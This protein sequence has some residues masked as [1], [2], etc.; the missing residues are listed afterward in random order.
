MKKLFFVSAVLVMMSISNS[1]AKAAEKY[2]LLSEEAYKV[3]SDYL[4][5][6]VSV[7]DIF[8]TYSMDA[9]EEYIE[10]YGDIDDVLPLE[11]GIE[12]PERLNSIINPYI[13]KA[14]KLAEAR[15]QKE[16]YKKR[17]DLKPLKNPA[18]LELTALDD[19]AVFGYEKIYN[20]EETIT[21]SIWD[22]KPGHIRVYH[23]CKICGNEAYEA[24]E[25][26]WCGPMCDLFWVGFCEKCGYEAH[27]HVADLPEAQNDPNFLKPH[28]YLT[29][30]VQPTCDAEGKVTTTC[31]M[32]LR[33]ETE[34]LPKLSHEYEEQVVTEPTFF[35]DGEI[36]EICK[37]CGEVNNTTVVPSKTKELISRLPF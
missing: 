9:I 29:E 19:Y 35:K 34:V 15:N 33:E 22:E 25:G 4:N 6:G 27:D 30:R 36:Q 16:D 8:N 3:E 31:I 18:L 11:Q 37:L 5:G 20:M 14:S 26:D 12:N 21:D 2:P 23:L 13:E 7:K 17:T 24:W 10:K 1:T 28:E 32:C